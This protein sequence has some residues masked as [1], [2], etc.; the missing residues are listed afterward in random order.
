MKLTEIANRINKHL[1]RFEADPIVNAKNDR[2]LMPYY[3]AQAY[4]VGRWVNIVYIAYHGA[5]HLSREEAEQYLA[6][7]DAGNVG[8][9]F[10]QR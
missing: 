6:W 5:N 1:K 3:F 2:G 9:H 4:S 8:T 10:N 7:L